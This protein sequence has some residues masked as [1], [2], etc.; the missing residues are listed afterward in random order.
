MPD[1][2]QT[3][4]NHNNVDGNL[5]NLYRFCRLVEKFELGLEYQRIYL[6]T[7]HLLAKA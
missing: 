7:T 2:K 5:K 1:L 4:N 3:I 6:I